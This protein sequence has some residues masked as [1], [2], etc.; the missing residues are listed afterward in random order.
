LHRADAGATVHDTPM[1]APQD[2][3]HAWRQLTARPTVSAAIV[4]TLGL[5]LGA[6]T[7]VFSLVYGILLRPYPYVAPDR[8]VR[9]QTVL[10]GSL[11]NV[12]GVSLPDL[13]DL[14]TRD[15]GVQAYGA[16]LAFPNTL[17]RTS[18]TAT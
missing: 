18:S 7:A 3:L 14:R 12:R 1:N 13:E 6:S 2:V 10:P 4:I 16:Y 5:G 11:A 15:S 17:R 9:V 8:L